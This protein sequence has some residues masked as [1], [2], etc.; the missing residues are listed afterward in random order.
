MVTRCGDL[1]A[2]KNLLIFYFIEKLFMMY[3]LWFFIGHLLFFDS[4]PEFLNSYLSIPMLIVFSIIGLWALI[5]PSCMSYFLN[6]TCWYLLFYVNPFIS[7]ISFLP[8]TCFLFFLS[9]RFHYIN[10]SYEKK[11]V[12]YFLMFLVFH[13]F[14]TGFGKLY[15]EPWINGSALQTI[16]TSSISRI[17]NIFLL[18]ENKFIWKT[19][20][21]AVIA[22]ELGT[23]IVFFKKGRNIYIL[24]LIAFHTV[25]GFSLN[26]FQLSIPYILIWSWLYSYLNTKTFRLNCLNS[27]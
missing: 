5:K 17:E 22:F 11:I 3:V 1:S 27:Y 7:F 23:S 9:V 25:I 19:L 8:I 4:L 14:Q 13:Y 10:T 18:F 2:R 21:Y 12:V 20:T 6:G 26:A 24:A 16:L 15:S